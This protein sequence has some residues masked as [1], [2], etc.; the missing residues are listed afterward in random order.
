MASKTP[1]KTWMALVDEMVKAYFDRAMAV[2]I[3]LTCKED[4][5][6]AAMA[7]YIRKHPNEDFDTYLD[8]AYEIIDEP[9]PE[10][11]LDGK[12]V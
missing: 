7:E 5:H 3:G 4:E 12:R 8:K 9:R 2:S 10:Y 6:A 11:F 1:S